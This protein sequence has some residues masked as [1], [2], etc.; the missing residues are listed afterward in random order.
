MGGGPTA[1]ALPPVA[2]ALTQQD[3]EDLRRLKPPP[4]LEAAPGR[5]TLELKGDAR[6]LFR[7]VAKAFALDCVFDADYQPG[8]VV[9]LRIEEADYQEALHQLEAVT[10]SFVAPVSERLFLV[11]KD[12]PQKRAEVEPAVA[13][14]IHIP[15]PVSVQ[16]AQEL[17]RAVQQAMEILRLVVDAERRLV[18][19]KDRVSK[20]LPAQALF[21][22]LAGRRAQVVVELELLEV[23]RVSFLSY[24][25][26]T[27]TEFPLAYLGGAFNSKPS[28]AADFVRMLVFG[29]GRTLLGFGLADARAF[30]SMNRSTGRT[31]MRAEIRALDGSAASF[32]VGDRYP[33]LAGAYMAGGNSSF[34]APPTF[35][36]EDLGMTLKVTPRVHGFEEVS[37]E[38]EAEFK[39]L[40]GQSFNG[41]PVISSR[42]LQS[43]VRLREGQWGVVA[44]LMSASEARSVS[45]L[46]GLSSLPLVGR[47]FRQNSRT[48]ESTEVLLLLKP[49]LVSPP[50]PGGET[51]AVYLGSE[52]RLRIPL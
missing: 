31:L 5:R 23:D 42:K 28:V 30:A 39:V 50:P 37:L 49:R 8:P 41:I 13:V 51:P 19:M 48:G 14:G 29:G 11:A 47:A 26:T 9:R 34:L 43:K 2:G 4:R 24:G 52:T 36:F 1:P 22:Q 45:G 20:V 25:L 21:E 35:N 6:A 17:A 16:E 46:A 44:G 10:A 3:L 7:Q 15:D 27:P 38:L 33:V 32:H 18:F 40:G 12:T